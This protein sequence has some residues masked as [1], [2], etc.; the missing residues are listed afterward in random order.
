MSTGMVFVVAF[1]N[2]EKKI[3][4]TGLYPAGIFRIFIHPVPWLWVIVPSIVIVTIFPDLVT[5]V[6]VDAVKMLSDVIAT[7]DTVK[8]SFSKQKFGTNI[9]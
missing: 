6:G 8:L 1:I 2:V 9:R 7:E 3:S 4:L 5:R